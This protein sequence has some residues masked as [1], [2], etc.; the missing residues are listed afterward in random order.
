MKKNR[1]TVIITISVL[2]FVTV[3][4]LV[5]FFV[6]RYTKKNKY[7]NTINSAQTIEEL[8]EQGITKDGYKKEDFASELAYYFYVNEY[9]EDYF[10]SEGFEGLSKKEVYEV[11]AEE[12]S[13]EAEVS[14]ML[15]E[16]EQAWWE[17]EQ[18]RNPIAVFYVGPT[19][20]S[21]VKSGGFFNSDNEYGRQEF[22]ELVVNKYKYIVPFLYNVGYTENVYLWV[23]PNSLKMS[24]SNT[25]S[26]ECYIGTLDDY[27]EK[28]FEDEKLQNEFKKV[29]LELNLNT[30]EW[31]MEITP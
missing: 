23:I 25:K 15:T 22:E 6:S 31:E 1:R 16:E 27:S 14:P 21:M 4:L 8:L 24:D 20:D 19:A 12:I 28:K 3:S 11:I 9:Y 17:E 2:L 30:W 10:G 18:L 5:M 13:A 26:F 7:E 29:K